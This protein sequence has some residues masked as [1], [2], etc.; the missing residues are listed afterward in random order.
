MSAA[1]N[2]FTAPDAYNDRVGTLICPASVR[3]R[4]QVNNQAIFWQRGHQVPGGGVNWSEAEE[5]LL[6][7]LYSFDET[8]EA[9][10]VR[11][12]I[13]GAQ[14]PAGSAQ[15]QVTIATRTAKELGE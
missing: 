8:C 7:G 12:A 14:L 4:L 5:F 13:P 3:V 6:P 11:A 2:N 1:L 10:R 9:T 15:A